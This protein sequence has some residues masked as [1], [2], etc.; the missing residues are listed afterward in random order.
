ML[1]S[2]FTLMENTT[3]HAAVPLD[4]AT[5]TATTPKLARS[6]EAV[7]MEKY[8]IDA[9]NFLEEARSSLGI[10]ETLGRYGFDDEEL[11]YGMALQ[12]AAQRA[13]G[14][15]EL[16]VGG[17]TLISR[18]EE[19]RDD[20]DEFRLITRAAFTNHGDRAALR[21]MGDVPDDLQRFVNLA[22]TAYEAAATAPYT[23]KMTKRG[24]SPDRLRTMNEFLDALSWTEITREAAAEGDA[25]VDEPTGESKDER[26]VAYNALKEFMKE[27]KGVCRAAFRK[28]P[29]TLAQLGLQAAAK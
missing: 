24:Y 13:L 4:L 19:A 28:Q 9:G 7:A 23:E 22:H 3:T 12:Q 2:G 16:G 18:V 17:G 10:S 6:V 8:I 15:S 14:A 25:S 11:T 5:A 27:I 29:D 20:F 1:V 26:D 21:V